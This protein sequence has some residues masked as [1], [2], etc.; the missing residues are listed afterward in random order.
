MPHLYADVYPLHWAVYLD[1]NIEMHVNYGPKTPKDIRKYM[2][3]YYEKRP[4][5]HNNCPRNALG[6]RG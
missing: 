4:L 6:S 3:K 1:H 2:K 5:H